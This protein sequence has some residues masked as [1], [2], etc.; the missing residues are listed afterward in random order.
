M[1]LGGWIFFIL[2]GGAI[3]LIMIYSYLKVFK[4]SVEKGGKQGTD[5]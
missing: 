5:Q 4:D 1:T 3:T 2:A